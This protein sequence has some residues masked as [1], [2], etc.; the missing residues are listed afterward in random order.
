MR[1]VILLALRESGTVDN[2]VLVA[3]DDEAA[4][5]SNI[6]TRSDFFL[7]FSFISVEDKND[8]FILESDGIDRDVFDKPNREEEEEGAMLRRCPSALNLLGVVE[9]AMWVV[10]AGE[11]CTIRDCVNMACKNFEVGGEVEGT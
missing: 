2:D 9:V 4:L 10:E 5:V 3:I 11:A 8:S 1:D 6:D 7:G